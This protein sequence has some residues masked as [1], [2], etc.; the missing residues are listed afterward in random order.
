MRSE[1]SRELSR[2]NKS[3]YEFLH[4][5]EER[6]AQDLVVNHVV[7]KADVR[8]STDLTKDILDR[9]M[10]PASHFSMNLHE[11]VKRILERYGAA[12]VFIE[13]DAIIL[14]IYEHESTRTTRRAVA[15]ACVLAR[16][17]LAV[18]S[19]YNVRAKATGLPPLELGVGVAFQDSAPA[20]WMDGDSKIMISKALNLS[21]RLSSCSKMAKRLFEENAS[22]FNV[23]LVQPLMEEGA[24]DEEEIPLIR[25][26]LNG[27]EL[28][29]EGFQKLSTEIAL[30]PMVGNFPMAW[31]KDKRAS[32]FW[33][34]SPRRVARANRDSQRFCAPV[35]CRREDRGAR[36]Q[37][38]LRSLHRSRGCSIS[39][40]RNSPR[41]LPRTSQNWEYVE[42]LLYTLGHGGERGPVTFVA[43]KAID[44]PLCGQG[45]GFDS[46]TLP[47][48][49]HFRQDFHPIAEYFASRSPRPFPSLPTAKERTASSGTRQ[50]NSTGF[51]RACEFSL[52][53][54]VA[55]S[56]LRGNR[57]RDTSVY[58]RSQI[59]AS[60]YRFVGNT[61]V[62]S[63][64]KPATCAGNTTAGGRNCQ[65]N[66]VLFPIGKMFRSARG[67]K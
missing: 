22:P 30:A 62:K 58:G 16:E 50:T 3:L 43:F 57:N 13:G 9:G 35:A 41:H 14:A 28:N 20:L 23:F 19:H 61:S 59:N 1:H 5:E 38:V 7:I 53:D 64:F 45:G 65:A 32:L 44:P 12:K 37:S 31:G 6:P 8:G 46:H 51:V 63:L 25:Y 42:V 54:S 67:L 26:N 40:A 47:P 55:L 34:G 60:D 33:R 18:T 49:V 48:T 11:P 24:G 36:E 56:A 21:D 52:R 2:A 15:R 27:I 39:L 10:N 17:I 4:P 66:Q 29:E